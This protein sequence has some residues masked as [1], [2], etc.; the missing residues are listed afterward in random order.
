MTLIEFPLINIPDQPPEK[1]YGNREYK[2]FLDF[3]KYKNI[4]HSLDKKATQMLFRLYE[5]DGIAK[6]IIGV[7]D[8]GE[9]VGMNYI[10]SIESLHFLIKIIEKLGAKLKKVR[11][12]KGNHGFIFAAHIRKDNIQNI[13]LNF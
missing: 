5:G 6:Y 10:K 11:F 8:N 7:K 4:E 3:S 9:A 1:Y 12:Y 13:G 2:I